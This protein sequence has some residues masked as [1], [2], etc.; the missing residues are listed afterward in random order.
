MKVFTLLLSF[1]NYIIMNQKFLFF[2]VK[3]EQKTDDPLH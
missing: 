3:T 1:V 2:F